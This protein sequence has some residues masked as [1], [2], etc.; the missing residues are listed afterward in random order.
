MI[1]DEGWRRKERQ[2]AL[3]KKDKDLPLYSLAGWSTGTFPQDGIFLGIEFLIPPPDMSTRI[4]RLEMTRAQC[5]ELATALELVAR[6]PYVP[7][8]EP[9]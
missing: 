9:G 2:E 7:P 3:T 4:L 8:D 5:A 1:D 6:T